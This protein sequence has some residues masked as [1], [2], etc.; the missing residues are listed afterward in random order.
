MYPADMIKMFDTD[1]I[2][3]T[4]QQNSLGDCYLLASYVALDARP[5]AIEN[6]FYTKEINSAGIYAMKFQ[7]AG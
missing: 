7:I 5:G 3:S 1:H 4:M 2:F 6:L